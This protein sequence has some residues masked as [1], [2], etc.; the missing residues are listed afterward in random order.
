MWVS[1]WPRECAVTA[2]AGLPRTRA[3]MGPPHMSRAVASH[4]LLGHSGI[5]GGLWFCGTRVPCVG[6]WFPRVIQLNSRVSGR[7]WAA[8][9]PSQPLGGGGG[10]KTLSEVRER[11]APISG[12]C[13]TC[14]ELSRCCGGWCEVLGCRGA[15]PRQRPPSQCSLVPGPGRA[16][17]P[18]LSQL[19]AVLGDGRPRRSQQATQ[20]RG[21]PGV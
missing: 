15:P 19:T 13:G 7:R 16:S 4:L 2:G 18:A 14:P 21:H 17:P 11:G 6:P 9:T 10:Q 1:A 12:G 3:P 20:L 8:G 5:L